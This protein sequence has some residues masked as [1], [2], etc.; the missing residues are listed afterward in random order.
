[1]VYNRLRIFRIFPKHTVMRN[2]VH[3]FFSWVILSCVIFFGK[4]CGYRLLAQGGKRWL[5]R[6][7]CLFWLLIHIGIQLDMTSA[8]QSYWPFLPARWP[9]HASQTLQAKVVK[10]FSQLAADARRPL[11]WFSTLNCFWER[12]VP[13]CVAMFHLCL[14][15]PSDLSSCLWVWGPCF[16]RFSKTCFCPYFV[17]SWTCLLLPLVFWHISLLTAGFYTPG[18]TGFF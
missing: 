15:E 12:P 17:W 2:S 1:M 4:I 18:R 13:F 6:H 8:M 10:I 7:G 16:L 3:R 14:A 9:W 11:H 5:K